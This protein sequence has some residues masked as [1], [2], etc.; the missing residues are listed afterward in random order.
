[1]IAPLRDALDTVAHK[2][3]RGFIVGR[4]MLDHI[5]EVVAEAEAY[6]LQDGGFGCYIYLDFAA[7]FP[8][9]CHDYL[10]WVLEK[11]GIPYTCYQDVS[12]S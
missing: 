9:L 7:A 3:Q 4:N 8:S 10:F 2:A 12:F 5:F 1:M 11:M 6:A